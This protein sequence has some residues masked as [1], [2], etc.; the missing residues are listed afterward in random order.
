MNTNWRATTLG[1]LESE[2]G[3][4]IQTGPFGSQL[5]SSDYSQTGSPVVMPTNIRELRIDPAGI[6]R[7][8]PK[9]VARL[10]R[11]VLRAGDIVYSRRGDVEKCAL[12]TEDE[13]GWLCGTGCL[14]VRVGSEEVDARFVAYS[15]SHPETRA[16]ISQHAVGATMPN[17][18]TSI[19]RKV[20]LTLPPIQEQRAIAETLAAMDDKIK[21]NRR[22]GELSAALAQDHFRA[23]RAG[24]PP[25]GGSSR[26]T[27]RQGR[28][29]DVVELVKVPAKA[30]EYPD[31]P[32]VPIDMLPLRSL[33]LEEYR[34]NDEAQSSLLRFEENDILIGAMRVYFH[35]V[36]LAP[37]AGLTRT[38]SFVLRARD[39][40][41]LP[42][43]LLLCNE[44]STI[45]YAQSTSKGST[46]PYAVW[47]GGLAE[48]PTAIPP[49]DEAVAFSEYV[50]PLLNRVR[51]GF[52]EQRR[53]SAMRDAL[54]PEL[55]SGRIQAREAAEAIR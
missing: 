38:T 3:G 13:A 15:L 11:H 9:H 39:E 30:G 44:A 23:W 35:R 32:Y 1:D 24:L 48:L 47:D 26:E 49:R 6:A 36:V 40:A 4:V 33:G 55:L 19:L 54:L 28:L 10:S 43:S 52:R 31:L 17:L 42:F 16:W 5:H 34:A 51:D 27:W 8:S 37:F 53:L 12:I 45:S 25:W 7:V 50:R 2:G 41:F 14:L 22:V 21:S 20:P 46:M 29:G 18:N